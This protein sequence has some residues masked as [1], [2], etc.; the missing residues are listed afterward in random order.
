MHAFARDDDGAWRYV[1]EA[2]R[3]GLFDLTWMNHN[4]LLERLRSHENFKRAQDIVA[5]RA[6]PVVDAWR[7]QPAG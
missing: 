3:G 5:A 4:P 7:D 2:V 6:K 1:D